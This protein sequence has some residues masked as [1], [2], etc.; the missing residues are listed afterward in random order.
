M[1]SRE[2]TFVLSRV[3]GGLPLAIFANNATLDL[4]IW[5]MIFGY[6]LQL[7]QALLGPLYNNRSQGQFS[8][9]NPPKS[10]IPMGAKV[11]INP[12]GF[13]LGIKAEIGKKTFQS[14]PSY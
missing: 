8:T 12:Q 14:A 5:Q 1:G 10:S 3:L 13:T 11:E 9:P 4:P 2:C 6:N 7:C